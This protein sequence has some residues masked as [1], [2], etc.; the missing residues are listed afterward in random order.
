MLMLGLAYL[1]LACSLRPQIKVGFAGELS[2]KQSELGI[3]ARNGVQLAVETINDAGG[4]HGRQ[5]ELLVADDH[6]IPE[7]AAEA[8]A[9]LINAGVVAVIGHITS[10]QTLTGLEVTQPRRVVLLS[11]TA[12]SSL[13]SRK[14]DLFFRVVD[15]TDHANRF[16]A[17]RLLERDIQRLAILYDEENAAFTRQFAASLQ[18]EFVSRGGTVT[19]LASFS[20]AREVDYQQ[21]VRSLQASEPQAL[22]I[23]ASALDTAFFAQ[24]SRLIG[25]DVPLFI[26]IWAYSEA[27][28]QNGG[29]AIEGAE[30]VAGFDMNSQSPEMQVFNRRYRQRFGYAPNFAAALGYEAML[31]LAEA[32][33]QSGGEAQGLPQALQN[34]RDF[35]GL[36][37]TISINEFGDTRRPLY[38]IRVEDKAF[39]TLANLG[40]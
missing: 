27:F 16:L 24:H 3:A 33:K 13:L 5:I 8:A 18:N 36:T 31:V 1:P 29:R 11:P 38:L 25:W 22:A 35:H 12:S 40:Y 30:L 17:Q 14:D 23:A 34:I 7:G 4:I 26:T 39:T 28:I 19:A 20:S 6:G 37:G 32:L 21:I 10:Q 15:N 9:E 2:G